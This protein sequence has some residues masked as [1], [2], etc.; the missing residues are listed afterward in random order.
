MVSL[1]NVAGIAACGLVLFEAWDCSQTPF[2]RNH[3]VSRHKL[4][5]GRSWV[6]SGEQYNDA[7]NYCHIYSLKSTP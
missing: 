6:H 3:M 4:V 2:W 7:V 5:D 1:T